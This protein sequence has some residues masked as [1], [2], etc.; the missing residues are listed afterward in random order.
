MGNKNKDKEQHSDAEAMGEKGD[1]TK[2]ASNAL[3]GQQGSSHE[4][5]ATEDKL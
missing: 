4:R 2:E 1:T 5:T 3:P